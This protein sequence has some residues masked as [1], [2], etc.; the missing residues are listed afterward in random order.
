MRDRSIA[1]AGRAP[2]DDSHLATGGFWKRMK[3]KA[4]RRH[5]R[6]CLARGD[7]PTAAYNRHAGWVS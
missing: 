6:R 2:K 3:A 5:A 7:Q 1:G 4:E